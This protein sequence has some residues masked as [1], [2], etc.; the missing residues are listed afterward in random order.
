MILP[1]SNSKKYIKIIIGIYILYVI[2]SPVIIFATGNEIK[3]DQNIYDKYFN[4]SNE[5]KSNLSDFEYKN[6]N[7]IV[8]TYKEEIRKKIGNTIKELNY[9][10]SNISFNLNLEEGKITKLSISVEDKEELTNIKAV[11]KIE[12]GNVI[13][14]QEK[15]NLSRQEIE[16]IKKKL[17]EDFGIDYDEIRINSI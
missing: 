13:K 8:N 6:N 2:I 17:Q 15:N 12:I 5:Y 1:N 14:K 9:S 10:A 7:Y 16:K 4:T 3:I 11:E